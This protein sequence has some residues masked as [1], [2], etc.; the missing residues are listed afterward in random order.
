VNAEL[1][2]LDAFGWSPDVAAAFEGNAA[3]GL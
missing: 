1:G 2:Q 3:T